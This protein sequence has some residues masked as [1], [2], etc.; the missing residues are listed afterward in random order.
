ML[1]L[2]KRTRR[3]LATSTTAPT[4][5]PYALHRSGLS[6]S[7]E[8]CQE[9]DS[10]AN[11]FSDTYSDP[12]TEAEA[13]TDT[14]IEPADT[15]EDTSLVLEQES[16]AELD[17]EAEEILNDIARFKAEGPAKPNHTDHTKKLWRREGDFW[18]R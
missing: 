10:D 11:S 2:R 7:A 14:D 15:G 16:D 8:T 9:G 6:S 12:D 5:N 4:R 3:E 17:S 13:D 1:S 18:E